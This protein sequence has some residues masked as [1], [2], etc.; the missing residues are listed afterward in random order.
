MK[1]EKRVV[2]LDKYEYGAVLVLINEKRNNLIR[3][4]QN[5]DFINE[6][7]KKV[8]KAPSKKRLFEKREKSE[9]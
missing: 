2:E 9:R 7:L 5:T 3:E 4:R 6:I 1:S 8:I